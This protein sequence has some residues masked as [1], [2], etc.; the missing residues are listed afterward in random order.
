MGLARIELATSALSGR[1]ARSRPIPMRPDPSHSVLVRW[2]AR[3]CFENQR[4]PAGQSGSQLLG[5]SWDRSLVGPLPDS[6]WLASLRILMDSTFSALAPDGEKRRC[7]ITT[8]IP[9]KKD[10][11]RNTRLFRIGYQAVAVLGLLLLIPAI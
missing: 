6:S 9:M 7:A 1:C 8:A 3:E 2:L 5:Q 10:Y 11:E 4:D